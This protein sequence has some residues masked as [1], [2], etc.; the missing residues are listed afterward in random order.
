LLAAFGSVAEGFRGQQLH[1]RTEGGN[2]LR[3]INGFREVYV[4]PGSQRFHSIIG[5]RLRSQCSGGHTTDHRISMT[6]HLLDE[7]K[8]VNM[9]HPEIG[10]KHVRRVGVETPEGFSLR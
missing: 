5:S 8:I 3:G 2:Q 1:Q 7:L 4:K 9:R 6:S 10:E